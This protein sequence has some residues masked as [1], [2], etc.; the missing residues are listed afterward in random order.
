MEYKDN[1]TRNAFVFC[2]GYN[3]GTAIVDRKLEAQ[4]GKLSTRELFSQGLYKP[5]VASA[6]F[7]KSTDDLEW[8]RQQYS[9][10]TGRELRDV[11]A[12]KRTVGVGEVYA[13]IQRTTYL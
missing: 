11:E 7:A 9:E 2:I 13:T 4:Y 3:G 5:A 12:L 8:L 6:I 10:V 1:M